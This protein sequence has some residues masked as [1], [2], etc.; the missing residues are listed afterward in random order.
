M[1]R[2][3]VLLRR[4]ESLEDQVC[5]LNSLL[6]DGT[7]VRARVQNGRE[8]RNTKNEIIAS[9]NYFDEIGVLKVHERSMFGFDMQNLNHFSLILKDGTVKDWTEYVLL[10][11]AN[12]EQATAFRHRYAKHLEKQADDLNKQAA[13]LR[14]EKCEDK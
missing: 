9:P 6:L 3:K 5:T 14:S 4:I 7:A 13:D 1:V 11:K 2:K 10:G 8:M 12:K